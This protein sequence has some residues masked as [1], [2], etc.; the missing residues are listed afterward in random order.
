MAKRL[1]T[2]DGLIVRTL[3]KRMS[4][5]DLKIQVSIDM[6]QAD[7]K[8]LNNHVNSMVKR[9][10]KKDPKLGFFWHLNPNISFFIKKRVK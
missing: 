9:Y 7:V 2:K 6:T 3:D 10:G 8:A 4:L 5:L 1:V